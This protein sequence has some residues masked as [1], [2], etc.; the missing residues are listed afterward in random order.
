MEAYHQKVTY[1]N[2]MGM[3]VDIKYSFP[4]FFQGTTGEDGLNSVITK[5]SN[6]NQ[7]GSS[8]TNKQIGDRTITLTGI[9]KGNTKTE[10]AEYRSKLLSIFN[11]KFKGTLV[12]EFG[13]IKKQIECVVEAAPKFGTK[14]I[15][16]HES[17]MI[18]LFCP[19]PFW[20][21]ISISSE[22]IITWIGGM[23]FPFSFPVSFSTKG[24]PSK[25]IIND[26]DVETPIEITFKGPAI[27]PKIINILTGE[28]I[29]VKRTLTS[30]DT[31]VINTEFGNKKVEILKI[32]G[33]KQNAFNYID[34]N[35]SFFQLNQG[36]NVI[37][38]S[39][40]GLEP[41]SVAIKFRKRYLGV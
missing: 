32:D 33:T 35:S 17:F 23:S 24:D 10:L 29:R 4:Y 40:D 27:N 6:Y 28:F 38:Y 7:D 25:N 5:I 14:N 8:I 18:S 16:K 36:D 12:Y 41:S 2:D 30:D 31:L 34:L 9:I 15:W 19:N 13:E 1:I 3:S 22:E 21:D 39:T 37:E 20:K 26:G 11:P